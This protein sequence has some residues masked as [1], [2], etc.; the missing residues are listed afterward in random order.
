MHTQGLIASTRYS[1]PPFASVSK[2]KGVSH[3]VSGNKADTGVYFIS[4]YK[5]KL[6]VVNT[7]IDFVTL[8]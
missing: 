1:K 8:E 7:A 3:S 6:Y 2:P 4:G 5:E